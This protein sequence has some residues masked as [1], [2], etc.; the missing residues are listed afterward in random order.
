[1]TSPRELFNSLFYRLVRLLGMPLLRLF[2][3]LR[4]E[5]ASQVSS[6]GSLLVAANHC[7]FMDPVVLQAACPRRIIFMMTERYYNPLWGRWFFKQMQAI[8]LREN[9]VYNVGPLRK[10]MKALQE[11]KVIGLFPEG[12]ISRTGALQDG[13]PGILLLAQRSNAAILPAY[14]RGTFRALPR[15]AKFP[16][17]GKITVTFG[18]PKSFREL[19]AGFSGR[20]GLDRA[21]KALM[22]EIKDLGNETVRL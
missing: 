10:G 13:Q 2:F 15:H 21:T 20:E 4:V 17:P 7:S 3:S 1:M 5:N 22:E 8:P 6:H 16:R 12:G 14:I 11:G 19:A 18:R 9:T